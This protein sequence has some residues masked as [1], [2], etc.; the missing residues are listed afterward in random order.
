[1]KKN[2]RNDLKDVILFDQKTLSDLMKEI[3][4]NSV[5]KKRQIDEL[6]DQLKE[7]VGSIGDATVLVPLIRD[8]LEISVKNEENLLK[9]AGIASKLVI[10]SKNTNIQN[11]NFIMSE[12]EREYLQKIAREALKNAD[13]IELMNKKI[14]AHYIEERKPETISEKVDYIEEKLKNMDL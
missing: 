1:M 2:M 10:G 11:N 8:Y 5:S 12:D 6:V 3:Y 13:S 4:E 14:P 7:F 9:L